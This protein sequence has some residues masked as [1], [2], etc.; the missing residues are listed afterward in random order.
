MRYPKRLSKRADEI[1]AARRQTAQERHMRAM[2]ALDE[3]H[4]EIKAVGR[5]LALLYAQ[6]ARAPSGG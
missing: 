2:E 1:L 6:R 5:E 4:P 3:Q